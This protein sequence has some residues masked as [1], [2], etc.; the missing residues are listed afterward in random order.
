MSKC[1]NC[2]AALVSTVVRTRTH[3]SLPDFATV[4]W[5]CGQCSWASG[6]SDAASD[7]HPAD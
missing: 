4:S 2:E 5:R 7:E 3:E 1:P 6:E